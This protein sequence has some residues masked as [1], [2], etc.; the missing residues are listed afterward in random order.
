VDAVFEFLCAIRNFW[1]DSRCE[2]RESSGSRKLLTLRSISRVFGGF[3]FRGGILDRA[4]DRAVLF[5]RYEERIR[6]RRDN[7][8]LETKPIPP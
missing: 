2:K 4:E 3:A 7:I 5:S 6:W 1:S 8:N